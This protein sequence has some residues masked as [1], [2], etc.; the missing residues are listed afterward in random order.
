MITSIKS[1]TYRVVGDILYLY[2]RLCF[3]LTNKVIIRDDENRDVF[4]FVEMSEK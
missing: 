2:R 1:I 4:Y 3:F